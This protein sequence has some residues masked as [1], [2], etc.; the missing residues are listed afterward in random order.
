MLRWQ[1]CEYVVCTHILQE[2]VLRV[3]VSK[4]TGIRGACELLLRLPLWREL[5]PLLGIEVGGGQ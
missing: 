4:A 5:S 1:E 3:R 2:G